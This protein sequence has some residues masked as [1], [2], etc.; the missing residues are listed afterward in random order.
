[1]GVR[2][3]KAIKIGKGSKINIA[4]TGASISFGGKGHSLNL[5]KN[6]PKATVGIP[7]TGISYSQKLG[8][9][10]KTHHKNEKTS[11]T[12]SN[13]QPTGRIEIH[14]NEKGQIVLFDGQGN[15]IT[16]PSIIKKIQSTPQF[17]EQK[18]LLELQR[19]EKIDEIV[20]ES[21]AENEAFI[22]IFKSSPI[23]E[24]SKAFYYQLELMKP[25]EYEEIPFDI[26]KPNEDEIREILTNE[27]KENVKASIFTAS[28]LRKKYVEDNFEDRYNHVISEWE[29]KKAEYLK[30]IEEEKAEAQALYQEEYENRKKWFK[31]LIEGEGNAVAEAFDA[32][33]SSCELPVEINI[34]YDWDEENHIIMLDV[35]LP[36]IED[37]PNTIMTKTDSGNLKEKKKTQSD[38]KKEYSVLTFGLAVFLSANAFNIS[39]AIE[40]VLISGYT[41]RRDNDGNVND[42]YIYSIKFY[43][44][45]FE[46]MDLKDID[47]KDFCMATEN[48]CNLSASSLFKT[49]KPYDSF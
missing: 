33:I 7:G 10:S 28:K 30:S 29:N 20:K 44:S 49:I 13:N 3:R 45:Q 16:D 25:D 26:P 35:D 21:E 32:W 12:G 4:K 5:G 39:P 9:T 43:R 15:E 42:D 40:K 46:G 11:N 23:V 24:D 22:N 2:F 31:S 18:T 36:E 8:A 41:Q 19:K 34:N 38:L 48:R 47:P 1:M 14:M 6:G 37:V 17:T 27:A